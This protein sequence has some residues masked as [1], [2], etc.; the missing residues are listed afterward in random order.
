[1]LVHLGRGP[2]DERVGHLDDIGSRLGYSNR[3]RTY[4]MAPIR[5]RFL[6]LLFTTVHGAHGVSVRSNIASL[7]PV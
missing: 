4:L 7:A 1:M 3:L 6:S 2:D 5:A